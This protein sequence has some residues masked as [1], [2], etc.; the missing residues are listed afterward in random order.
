MLIVTTG[1][2]ATVSTSA[3]GY[4]ELRNY[5][6]SLGL[7]KVGGPEIETPQ[8]GTLIGFHVM[9]GLMLAWWSAPI[10]EPEFAFVTRMVVGACIGAAASF[11]LVLA[12][13]RRLRIRLTYPLL[14]GFFGAVAAGVLTIIAVSLL[15]RDVL[16][17]LFGKANRYVVPATL[18]GSLRWIGGLFI[19]LRFNRSK[20]DPRSEIPGPYDEW[21]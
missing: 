7:P 12:G 21:S 18:A 11:A 9:A 10:R 3:S 16:V 4:P 2:K 6:Q 15:P 19:G 5:F 1:R 20:L 14:G 13:E 17:D 8:M